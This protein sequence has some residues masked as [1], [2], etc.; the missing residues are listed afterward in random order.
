MQTPPIL[1][2]CLLP[3][4]PYTILKKPSGVRTSWLVIS[5][6]EPDVVDLFQ[7]FAAL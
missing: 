6:A 7:S 4:V 2:T 5:D 3:E 1:E